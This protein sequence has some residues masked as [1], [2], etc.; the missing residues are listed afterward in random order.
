METECNDKQ[1][2]GKQ[3]N[4]SSREKNKIEIFV[5]KKKQQ[6]GDERQNKEA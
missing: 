4:R 3:V 1:L 5:D 6:A 2:P